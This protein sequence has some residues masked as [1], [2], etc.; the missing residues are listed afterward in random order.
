MILAALEEQGK[1]QAAQLQNQFDQLSATQQQRADN[2]SQHLS[3]QLSLQLSQQMSTWTCNW[4]KKQW[5]LEEDLTSLKKRPEE[6][7]SSQLE[8]EREPG[9]IEKMLGAV[10]ERGQPVVQSELEERLTSLERE[11]TE[12]KEE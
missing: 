10:R 1:Q 4:E 11:L 3:H 9:A 8:L 7:A 6:W 5:G 2:F 12:L